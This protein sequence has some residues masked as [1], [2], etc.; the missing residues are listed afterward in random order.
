MLSLS[1]LSTIVLGFSTPALA[2]YSKLSADAAALG[3]KNSAVENAVSK[4]QAT[5]TVI[6]S[7]TIQS[8]NE[9][10]V[11]ALITGSTATVP[12]YLNELPTSL[13]QPASS[14]EG[15][16]AS[17]VQIDLVRALSTAA[18]NNTTARATTTSLKK[19]KTASMNA[20]KTSSL[21]KMNST[22]TSTKNGSGQTTGVW[23]AAGIAGVGVIGAMLLL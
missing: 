21:T 3:A 18:Y 23:M 1:L 8:Q 6:A 2:Q 11:E 17:L 7:A 14:L 15:A 16:E 19:S 5:E 4:W 13:R 12:D 22:A 9:A 20:T 10:Y